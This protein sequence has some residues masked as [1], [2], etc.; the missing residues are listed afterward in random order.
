MHRIA[1]DPGYALRLFR[2]SPAFTATA[3]TCLATLVK[4]GATRH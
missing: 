1:R 4:K 3:P 2:H